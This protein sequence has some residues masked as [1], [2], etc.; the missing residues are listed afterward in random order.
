MRWERIEEEFKAN[1]ESRGEVGAAFAAVRDGEVV[2][3]LWGGVAD[4]ATGRPWRADTL[5]LVF[6]GAKGLVAASILLLIQRG[7][8][9]LDAPVAKYW[10]EFAANGKGEITVAQVM[11]HQARLPGIR[12]K[13]SLHDILD[14]R[15]MTE[16]V[17]AQAP[18][19]DPRAD[20]VY[21]ALNYGW[22]AGELVR[23]VDGREVARFFADEFARPLELDVWLG[24]PPEHHDRVATLCFAAD[25]ESMDEMFQGDFEETLANPVLIRPETAEFLN[26]AA[27]ISSGVPG[28]GAFGTAKSLALFYGRLDRILTP[29]IIRLGRTELR[30]GPDTLLGIHASHG[31]GF[32]LD[33]DPVLP[34]WFGHDG[35]GGSSHGAWPSLN[36]AYSYT[37]NSLSPM[38]REKCCRPMLV[39]LADALSAEART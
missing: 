19:T 14:S 13:V 36:A 15:K 6:S 2:V 4:P 21:H 26:S 29:G 30:G 24:V 37:M 18:E 34:D 17:A 12:T 10:P 35:A 33:R 32:Q 27:F 11:S 31:V 20:F 1:F 22:L 23:R 8:L 9:S 16:I 3:D 5:Q 28:A 25:W 38:R 7:R 39:A